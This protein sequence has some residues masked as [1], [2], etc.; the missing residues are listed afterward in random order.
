MPFTRG[1]PAM[2][3]AMKVL[4]VVVSYASERETK[5]TLD[6]LTSLASTSAL[7]NQHDWI[8]WDNASNSLGSPPNGPVAY[9]SSPR[10][11]IGFGAAVNEAARGGSYSRLLLLN[12]DIDLSAKQLTSLF[13]TVIGLGPS[14]IWAPTLVNPDG[15]PQ[16]QRES[17]FLKT[18]W[19]EAFDV[20]GRPPRS[21]RTTPPLH[22]LRGAVF[23]I[24]RELFEQAEGFDAKFFLYGEE[25]DLCFR[26]APFSE[27]VLDDEHRIMHAGSQ[28]SGGKSRAAL[29]HS[30]RARWLLQRRYN[31]RL[32]GICTRCVSA[33]YLIL[34]AA[35][36]ENESKRKR[37]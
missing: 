27:L 26:L 33:V 30:L 5:R 9:V 21:A 35:T 2:T 32:A 24:S 13:K 7:A 31:G 25:A 8:L 17:L 19:Q 34:Y 14:V 29:K 20:F 37:S 23:S 22:Y 28:G 36:H 1:V 11:N 6:W 15:S 3:S 18:A 12:S 4:V 16:T 10:G